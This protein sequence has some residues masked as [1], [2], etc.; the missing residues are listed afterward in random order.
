MRVNANPSSSSI[1]C[2]LRILD[3]L[4]LYAMGQLAALLR[5]SSLIEDIAQIH[6]IVLYFCT[7]LS[8]AIFAQ[9]DLY[10]SWRG[11][12]TG[13]ESIQISFAIL[14]VLAAG[15]VLSFTIR[16][17]D[18]LSRLW[19]TY[20]AGLS[21][22][23]MVVIRP[24]LFSVLTVL[25]ASGLEN[26]RVMLIGY[27][28]VGKEIHR[29]TQSRAWT[30][31]EVSVIHGATET[32]DNIEKIT[33][34]DDIPHAVARLK[35]HEIWLALPLSDFNTLQSVRTLLSNL[36]VD[37][38]WVPDTSALTIL[39]NKTISLFDMPVVDLNRPAADGM[40]GI[41]KELFD[42]IFSLCALVCL[43]PLFLI[44]A[45][46]I[47]I[48]SPGPVFFQQPRLGVNGKYINVYKFRSM[49]IHTEEQGKI[50][51]ASRNDP[52]VTSIGKFIRRTSLDELPQFFN[53]LRGDMSV[54]GPRP[55][56]LQHNDLYKDKVAMYM[57][58]H[59][60]K[61]GITGWAQIHGLRGETDTNEKM[62]RR[63][64][65][66][67]HYIQNWSLWMDI[68]IIIWTACYGWKND[69]AY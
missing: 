33:K 43:T 56:A 68:K 62:A 53:V 31:Y 69:H 15:L 14:A 41:A 66:D 52:R 11:K 44:L 60:V 18:E 49:K 55:H 17:V 39:S 40:S 27:G 19:M 9:F 51:Q 4:M 1:E 16:E 26:K 37:I 23:A 57:Q 32:T 64:E 47:K 34:L 25:H 30:G 20:W 6:R 50:S 61:P 24:V 29:R 58:R 2:M 12:T 5:F 22:A 28:S 42:K 67:L 46:L 7:A 59:R 65:F 8:P 48:S 10:R 21:I 3:V 13:T 54:V 35:I 63:V 38:R 45:I 36:L